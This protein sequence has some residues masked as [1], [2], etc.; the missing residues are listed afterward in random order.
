M[1]TSPVKESLPESRAAV[2]VDRGDAVNLA[3][4]MLEASERQGITPHGVRMLAEGVMAM[5]A[6]LQAIA[7][8][9]EGWVQLSEIDVNELWRWW[10]ECEGDQGRE[11]MNRILE[12]GDRRIAAPLAVEATEK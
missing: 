6:A 11:L 4:N 10:N 8:P 7:A 1:N 2:Y 9:R 5:D 12:A 3:R